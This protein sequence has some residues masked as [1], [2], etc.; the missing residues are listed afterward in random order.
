[1]V[2]EE[3]ADEDEEE[4]EEAA[5]SGEKVENAQSESAEDE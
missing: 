1:M 3:D 4:S 5:K 2:E